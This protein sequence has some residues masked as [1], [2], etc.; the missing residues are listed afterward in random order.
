MLR[1]QVTLRQIN[2]SFLDHDSH[3]NC[4]DAITSFR[5]STIE[6]Q[7]LASTDRLKATLTSPS[8][9]AVIQAVKDSDD[10]SEQRKKWILAEL[11]PS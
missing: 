9:A 6:A 5:P 2:Y 1:C 11:D 7:I 10:I 4:A 3:L 8:R